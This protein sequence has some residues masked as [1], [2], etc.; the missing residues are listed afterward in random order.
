MKS[1]KSRTETLSRARHV[2]YDCT[3]GSP[4]GRESHG[5]RDFHSSRGGN[6]PPGRWRISKPLQG[7]GSQDFELVEKER[8]AQCKPP[9]GFYRQYTT[10]V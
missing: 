9:N 1:V 10:W 2:L 7:E 8:Y 6:V 4:K 3:A 5:D